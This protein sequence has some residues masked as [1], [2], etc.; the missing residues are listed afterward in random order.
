MNRAKIRAPIN[1]E[2]H[3]PNPLVVR[4]S[5]DLPCNVGQYVIV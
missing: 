1:G 4:K 5:G 3:G 2:R